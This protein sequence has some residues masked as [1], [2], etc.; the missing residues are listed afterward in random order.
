MTVRDCIAEARDKLGGILV[1]GALMRGIGI[2]IAE[3]IDI[4]S[5]CADAIDQ[6]EQGGK[7]DV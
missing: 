6:A 4:L 2:P 5:A 3:A 1:P 7:E